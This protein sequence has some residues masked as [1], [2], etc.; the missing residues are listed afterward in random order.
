M[1]ARTVIRNEWRLLMADR[2]LRLAL[3]L[4]ALLL[5]YALANGV[6]WTRFQESTVEV[7][8]A[9]NVERALA[10]E[11]ELTDIE[12]GAEPA[13]PFSDPRLPNVLGGRRGRHTAVLT[14]GPLTA[15]AVGQ[16]DLLPYYYDVNIYTN[17]SSFH[18]NGE[19]ESP[20]N[21]MVGRFDLAFVVVY[22]LPLLVLALSFNVLSEEREQGTLALTLS[23]PVSARGVVAAKLAFRALL[24][25][26]MVL[27]VSLAGILVAGDFGA[28][29]RI[30]LWC[31]AVVAYALFW[32]VLAAWVNS[33]RRSSA[34]NA[35]VLVG[36]WLVLVVVLPAGINIAAG[37]LHPL[38]SRVQMITA[39]REASNDAVNR[40]SELLARYLEDHP[41]M[42]EG[43]VAD[44]PGLG[45]LAWAATDA[46]NRR[47]EEVTAEHDASR[48][49]QIAL[50][51]R[52]RF[53]SPALMAQE[54]LLDAAGTGD[55]RFAGFQSQVRAFAERWRDF[56]VPAIVAGEQMD[57]GA[58]SRAPQFRLADEASGEVTRRAAVPL[59]VLGG[60]LIL[61]GAGAGVGLGRVRG[62]S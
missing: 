19:V 16:S 33:L 47:L 18:Q 15:L 50:V 5:V 49:E 41:E 46:V 20:L 52:Y 59:T 13:S 21:L 39:Q 11:Q 57:A 48:A 58:Y 1:T 45:A 6:V 12:N 38:P 40:R 31:A 34:W 32:F 28:P 22:L 10:I 44:E 8:Q 55:A 9:G 37:L 36:A 2:P 42:A 56:F 62:A 17:E 7:A 30:L 26:G 35:T 43:V 53:L 3:G 14:P 4:F 23:Q 51:R 29:G 24:V 60:L 54:V 61:V 25:V 27:A